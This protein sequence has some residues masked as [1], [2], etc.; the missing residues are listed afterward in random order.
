MKLEF[1]IG[2]ALLAFVI[3][4]LNPQTDPEASEN[5]FQIDSTTAA[6]INSPAFN[7]QQMNPHSASVAD[8]NQLVLQAAAAIQQQDPMQAKLRYTIAMFGEEFSGPGR[9]YQM[10]QG[11]R[12]SR[13]EFDFGFNESKVRLQQFCDGDF[14]YSLTKTEQQ[15]YLEY[16]D[17]RHLPN[18]EETAANPATPAP[19]LAMGSLTG[20]LQQCANY[21]SFEHTQQDATDNTWSVRGTWKREALQKVLA[22]Q[23]PAMDW[24]ETEM[25][26]EKV[27]EQIPHQVEFVFGNEAGFEVFP[28]Q[29]IFWRFE[30]SGENRVAKPMITL[31]LY[32]FQS[33]PT[34]SEAIFQLPSTSALPVDR[35]GFYRRRILDTLR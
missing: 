18:A 34:M 16:V 4:R 9:Y 2:L 29:I 15:A 10:G 31:E 33:V 35:T 11:S 32:E 26:W 22:G 19:G 30:T 12:L 17:L 7:S 24:I 28:R 25:D 1:L 6:A 27:P 3:V 14:L 21:F 5:S 13:I 23:L 20:L 8:A